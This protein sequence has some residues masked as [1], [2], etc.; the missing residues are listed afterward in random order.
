MRILDVGML[1]LGA[2]PNDFNGYSERVFG[3]NGLENDGDGKEWMCNCLH[4]GDE[5]RSEKVFLN[6][7]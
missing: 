6:S 1:L 4:T 5:A 3:Y 7:N 2:N